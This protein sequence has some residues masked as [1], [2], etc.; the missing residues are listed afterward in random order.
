MARKKI[1][2]KIEPVKP[3]WLTKEETKKFLGCSDST[4][5]RLRNKSELRFA[6]YGNKIL[7]DLISIERF[8]EK[9]RVN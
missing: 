5:L 4:L 6:K 1:T 7:Y 9:N 8:I 2:V 3:K